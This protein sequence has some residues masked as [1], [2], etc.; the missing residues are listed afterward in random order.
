[1]TASYL[2]EELAGIPTTVYVSTEFKYKKKFINSDT[3]YIFISQSGET[4]DSLESLKVVK[5]K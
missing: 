3:L 1:M 2:F 5:N 4:A